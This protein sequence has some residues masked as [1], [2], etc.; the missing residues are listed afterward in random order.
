VEAKAQRLLV[1]NRT[2]AHAQEL[3]SRHGG[4]ALPLAELDRTWPRPTSSSPPPPA[5]TPILQ[6]AGRTRAAAA[7]APADAAARPGRAARHRA[8]RGGLRDVFL[9]TVDDLERAIEDNRRSRREAAEQAEAIIDLQVPA[10]SSLAPAAARQPLQA[11]AC[12]WRRA[13]RRG[14][15][16]GAAA[17]GRR[18]APEQALDL[19]AHTLTNRLLHAPT[20]ALREAALSGDGDLARAAERLF[21]ATGTDRADEDR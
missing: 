7:P 6:R 5:A 19:L 15:G 3:A 2:L 18:D 1:A 10:T 21:P 4:M 11:P 16:Q 20:A 13:A 9:Y 8:G 17:T 14:A 12:A